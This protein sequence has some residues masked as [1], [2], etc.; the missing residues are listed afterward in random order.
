[1]S[2]PQGSVSSFQRGQAE[3]RTE[4][5]H[6]LLHWTWSKEKPGSLSLGETP[7]GGCII[8]PQADEVRGTGND[9]SFGVTGVAQ[10]PSWGADQTSG[11]RCTD[12]TE[13]V[14]SGRKGEARDLHSLVGRLKGGTRLQ[15]CCWR[16]C[17][18]SR[19]P[20][21]IGS[22]PGIPAFLIDLP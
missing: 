11:P 7:R 18:S 16:A 22:A 19:T 17:R 6:C 8:C 10:T 1:M 15:S 20:F 2:E 3:L 9:F 5:W 21:F 12:R 13:P 4:L 14:C